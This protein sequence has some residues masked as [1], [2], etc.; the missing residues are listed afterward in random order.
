MSECME[1]HTVSK[2]FGSPLG[3]VGFENGGQLTEAVRHRPYSVILFNEI[4]KAHCDIL[5]VMLQVL[6]DG[7]LTDNEGGAEKE[8]QARVVNRIDEVIVF[9]SLSNSQLKETVE[10]MLKQ[11][12][13]RT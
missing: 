2:F 10:I 7:P 9:R 11:V 13:E 3:Y 6:D 1:R 4:E 5:N 8:F 12:S